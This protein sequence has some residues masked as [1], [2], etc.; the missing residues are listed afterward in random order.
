[1]PS[2]TVPAGTLHYRIAGPAETHRPAGGLRP[3]VPRR[4]Q[5]V[6][7]GRR[8]ASPPPVSARTSS[9]GRSAAIARRWPTTPTCPP[10]ASPASSTT[11]S[12]RSG[13]PMSRSSATTPAGPS[14]SSCWPPM[15]QR[16]GRVVLTNCDAFENFPPKV[17]VPLF[18]AARHPWLTKVLLAPMR[19]RPVRHSPLAYGLLL[20]R[21]RHAALTRQWITPAMTDRRIRADIA[22]FARGVD[23]RQPRHRGAAPRRVRRPGAHRVGHGRPLLHARHGA[24]PRRRVPRRRADRGARGLDVRVD[25]RT[26]RGQRRDPGGRRRDGGRLTRSDTRG[27]APAQSG[28][29]RTYLGDRTTSS[30]FSEGVRHVACRVT[31]RTSQRTSEETLLHD[32]SGH[33]CPLPLDAGVRDPWTTSNVRRATG[34]R[35]A[36][37]GDR[38][39]APTR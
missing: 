9:T 35:A 11:C 37:R 17:F 32:C 14:A 4:Q 10:P 33:G 25:R 23:R 12:P 7:P 8:R 1:M 18:V 20:R 5:P 21:P 19:L 2:V 38:A 30:Q 29:S 3:R 39:G 22:R 13:S 31:R 6:G 34:A 36:A 15:P 26:G 24:A 16:I 27:S 28:T